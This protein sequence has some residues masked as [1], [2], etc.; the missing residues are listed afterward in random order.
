MLNTLITTKTDY[1]NNKIIKV[2]ETKVVA[3]KA[4]NFEIR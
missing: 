3:S 4:T 1:N 2:N